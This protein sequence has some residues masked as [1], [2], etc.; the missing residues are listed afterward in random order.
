MARTARYVLFAAFALMWALPVGISQPANKPLQPGDLF[1]R[2]SSQTL[3]G[4]TLE[5][6]SPTASEP[7]VVL[8]SFSRDGGR[9]CQMWSEHLSHDFPGLA[10]NTLIFLESVPTLFR[11]LALSGIKRAMPLPK[12]ERTAIL[13]RDEAL[14]RDRLSVV[15]ERHAYLL[16][17]GSVSNTHRA[18]KRQ[19][20]V[21]I[22]A[23]DA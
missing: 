16:L 15:D 6:P 1:P 14:W 21:T 11:G 20:N 7:A 23:M 19:L 3:T 12:Q 9:D 4:K 17:L 8:F 13:Y 18:T 22:L 5:L 10:S 2:F